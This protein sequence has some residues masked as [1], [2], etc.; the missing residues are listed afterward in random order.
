MIL[1]HKLI[2]LTT[3]KKINII[4]EVTKIGKLKIKFL[5]NLIFRRVHFQ[6][7]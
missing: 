3:A 2:I 7:Y 5:N 1:K 6:L 4:K